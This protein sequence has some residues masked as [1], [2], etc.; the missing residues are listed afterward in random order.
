MVRTA[1]RQSRKQ[2]GAPIWDDLEDDDGDA[3]VAYRRNAKDGL[4]NAC[5]VLGTD[6]LAIINECLT[7]VTVANLEVALFAYAA[8]G[9]EV[10]HKTCLFC[11][12]FI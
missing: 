1:L 4:Q 10:L 2:A 12:N 11:L 5:L 6:I 8:V 7:E 3:L 9:S